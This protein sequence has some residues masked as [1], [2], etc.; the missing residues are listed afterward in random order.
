LEASLGRRDNDL[1]TGNEFIQIEERVEVR[2][3]MA[4]DR[5]VARWPGNEVLA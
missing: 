3:A 2:G 5:A 1:I 4:R